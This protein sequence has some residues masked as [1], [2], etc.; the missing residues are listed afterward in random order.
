M[1]RVLDSS[2]CL[3]RSWEF[4][5]RA[6]VLHSTPIYAN[7]THRSTTTTTTACVF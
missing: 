1:S 3:E 6:A 4:G 2:G 7:V 5:A